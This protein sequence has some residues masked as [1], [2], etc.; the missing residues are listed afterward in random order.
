MRCQITFEGSERHDTGYCHGSCA[1][2]GQ[3]VLH[4]CETSSAPEEARVQSRKLAG[5]ARARGKS[6]P[7]NSLTAGGR[8]RM[9]VN[10]PV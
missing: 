1:C 9:R 8:P 3:D 6:A 7:A 4:T 10:P 5:A 2:S